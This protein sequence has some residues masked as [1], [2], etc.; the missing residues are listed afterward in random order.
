MKLTI[1]TPER[2]ILS[3]AAVK[4]VT[5]P[6]GQGEMPILPGHATLVST[7][8]TGVLVF[9]LENGKKEVAALSRGFIRVANDEVIILADR[10]ELS[11]EIDV[12]RAKKAQI[13]AEEKLH[14]KETFDQ[15]MIVWQEKWQE[16]LQ[17]AYIRQE[18]SQFLL[19]PH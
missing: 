11:N 17:R 5:V 15:D 14:A 1:A 19:P 18:A 8:G 2:R 7:L 4:T 6:G 9:E 10:L 3:S 16:K 12:E 13:K